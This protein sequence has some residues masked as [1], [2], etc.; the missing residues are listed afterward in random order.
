MLARR[1]QGHAWSMAKLPGICAVKEFLLLGV[2]EI[3]PSSAAKP[4]AEPVIGRNTA[5][6]CL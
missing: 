1:G 4:P 5:N 3:S 6:T 2:G